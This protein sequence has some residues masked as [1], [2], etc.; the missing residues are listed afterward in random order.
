MR[1]RTTIFEGDRVFY[2]KPGQVTQYVGVIIDVD[3]NSEL[4]NTMYVVYTPE[5]N[6]EFFT[7][8]Q[9]TIEYIEVE[10]QTHRNWL[11]DWSIPT[12]G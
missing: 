5:G 3:P 1:T 12:Q 6:Y 11:V 7:D 2:H 4:L 9:A 10:G 8:F